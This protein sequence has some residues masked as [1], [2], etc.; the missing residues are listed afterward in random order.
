M[1]LINWASKKPSPIF[2][3][4]FTF[5]DPVVI[6][7][8]R[9]LILEK[10]LLINLGEIKSAW[11]ISLSDSNFRTRFFIT[12]AVLIFV[13][14]SLARFLDYNEE[15]S[16]FAFKDPL[17]S[18]FEPVDLTWFT[19][20]LIYISLI[21][22]LVSISYHPENLLIALQSYSLV[23]FFR[24][25]TIF[26]LPLDEPSTTIS[27]TDPFVEF[28]GGGETLHRDL[29]FSGHTA[30]MF[31]FY[32]TS[33]NKTMRKIFLFATVLVAFAVLIQHVHYTIDVVAAPFFAYSSYR[34][35]LLI[36]S[37]KKIF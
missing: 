34:I 18:L 25:C 8:T 20:G 24:L 30:T 4:Y 2:S 16:G 29:F 19:F 23:F 12:A 32:L 6:L 11:R 27:L 37:G 15:L 31:I 14:L 9:F 10:V 33:V 21:V 3:F 7:Q 28:F 13:L 26:L 1:S 22:A 35:A 36:S 5:L 17:L